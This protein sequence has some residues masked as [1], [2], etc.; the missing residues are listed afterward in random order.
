MSN[1]QPACLPDGGVPRRPLPVVSVPQVS[2]SCPLVGHG[3]GTTCFRNTASGSSRVPVTQALCHRAPHLT[4]GFSVW[5]PGLSRAK[6]LCFDPS[7][8][9]PAVPSCRGRLHTR[10]TGLMVAGWC[11][12]PVTLFF[13]TS[14]SGSGVPRF[15]LAS[16]PD[17]T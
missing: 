12:Q 10:P 15:A 9:S 6:S 11:P 4:L 7:S 5:F 3:E 17:T 16:Q 8:L 14:N 13:P 1:C 2:R